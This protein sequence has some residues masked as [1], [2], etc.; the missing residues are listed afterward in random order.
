MTG[1]MQTSSGCTF[2]KRPGPLGPVWAL[3]P[4]DQ[5]PLIID[6]DTVAQDAIDRMMENNFSQLPARTRSSALNRTG[7]GSSRGAI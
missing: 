7:R 6:D 1:E 4:K 2:R 5:Q 3:L